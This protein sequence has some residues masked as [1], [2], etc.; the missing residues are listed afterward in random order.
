MTTEENEVTEPT[1]D[2]LK[3]ENE[4]AAF[5]AGFSGEEAPE[6]RPQPEVAETPEPEIESPILAGLTETELKTLFARMGEIDGIK[7]NLSSLQDKT[8]GTLGEYNSRIT[9]LSNKPGNLSLK[10]GAFAEL[11]EYEPELAEMMIK[12]LNEGL[13]SGEA[14]NPEAVKTMINEAVGFATDAE[15]KRSEMRLLRFAHKDLDT[16]T[17]TPDFGTWLSA[18]NQDV[19][20]LVTN[21][22]DAIAVAEE[23]TNFKEW[24]KQAAQATQ[25]KNKRFE[26]AILPTDGQGTVEVSEQSNEDA[27][28]AGFKSA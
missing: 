8:F 22:D 6:E 21:S 18:Q 11:T 5:E 4:E 14:Y 3:Q 26:S 12:G 1:E 9:E 28:L 20:N 2:D 7:Q 16:I 24:R 25:K 23:I 13:Q 27:F 17:Q 15:K 19:R 10:E